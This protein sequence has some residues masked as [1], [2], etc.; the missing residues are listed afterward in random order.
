MQIGKVS[1]RPVIEMDEFR[2][3]SRMFIEGIALED[4]EPPSTGCVRDSLTPG[5]TISTSQHRG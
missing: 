4:I 3:P 5:R 1:I 2:L